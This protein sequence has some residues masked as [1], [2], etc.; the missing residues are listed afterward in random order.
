MPLLLQIY[1]RDIEGV[2]QMMGNRVN[3]KVYIIGSVASGKTTLAKKLSSLLNIPWYELDDVVYSRLP[4]GDVKRLN[5]ERD[6]IFNQIVSSE[7]WII[8]G[9]YRE[10]FKGGFDT[11][12]IIIF[13]NTSLYKRNYRIFKRWVYQKLK[14]EKSGYIPTIKML[15]LMYRWSNGFEK[16]KGDILKILEPYKNKVVALNDT[17]ETNLEKNLIVAASEW[18]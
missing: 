4:N 7:K 16:K 15:L 17:S 9:V 8:E 14:L 10:C 2:G 1:N 18:M 12:D 3:S 11:A 5:E 13:L 6:C